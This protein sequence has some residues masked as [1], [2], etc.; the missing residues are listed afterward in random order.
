MTV[1]ALYD[2]HG[3]AAALAAVLREVPL[4]AAVVVGGDIALGPQPLETL[5]LL[6]K[7]GDRARWIR[8][9]CERREP[10]DDELWE[11]RRLWTEEQL[12]DDRAG[13]LA[14]LP[15]TAAIEVE[16]LGPTLFCHGSPRSDEEMLTAT[17]SDER[18]RA[19]LAGVDARVVVC[20]HT[21]HQFDRRI[22]EVRVVNAGS[23]GMAY[24]G[25]PGAHWALLGPDVELRRTEYDVGAA[26][27]AIRAGTYPGP[28]E[29]VEL[30]ESPPA[31]AEVAEHFEQQA[32]AK[33]AA[34]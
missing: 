3:N 13:A 4:D 23:V 10:H 20:G 7:L 11:R 8:G 33:G 25:R 21:H 22:D 31:A 16:G 15:E 2:I 1:A 30:L 28:D 29:Q 24:E 5:E 14:A 26:A 34:V 12:G 19:I 18:L 32:L 9:N 17:S 6:G 27:R